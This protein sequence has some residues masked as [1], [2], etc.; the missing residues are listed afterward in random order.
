MSFTKIKDVDLKILSEL[1]DRD[2]L[3]VCITDKYAHMICQDEHF[4]RNRLVSKYGDK[5]F[6]YKPEN[7]KW[8]N[9]YMQII[10][11]LEG[12]NP[13]DFLNSMVWYPAYPNQSLYQSGSRILFLVD[14]PTSFLNNP[15]I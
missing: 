12:H 3:N 6:K 13:L 10:I 14:A 4:W 11:D 8:K 5:V 7:M 2:L 9:Y 15:L 1:P